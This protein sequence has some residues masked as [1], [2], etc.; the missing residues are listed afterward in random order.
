MNDA[1]KVM[2]QMT[3]LAKRTAD[4]SC[5]TIGSLSEG[6]HTVQGDVIFWPLTRMPAE[7]KAIKSPSRQLAE[8]DTK[9][10]RHCIAK[11]AMPH[12]QLFSL[13]RPNALQ[14]PIIVSDKNITIEHPEHGN[15]VL[16]PGNHLV[17]YQRAYAEEL[18]RIED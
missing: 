12:C 17:T 5:Q 14:G 4:D 11:D 9:G 13:P 15:Q 2:N 16:P 10:S 18:R 6:E 7:C 3:E 1:T 8:G